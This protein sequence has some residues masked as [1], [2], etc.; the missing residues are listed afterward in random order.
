MT[1]RQTG[2]KYESNHTCSRLLSLVTGTIKGS[3]QTQKGKRDFY[4]GWIELNSTQINQP[5]V[6]VKGGSGSDTIVNL[7]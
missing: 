6:N 3:G 7:G 4:K 5:A 1:D 2:Q